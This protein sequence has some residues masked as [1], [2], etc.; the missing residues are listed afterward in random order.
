VAIESWDW[1]VGIVGVLGSLFLMM[2]VLPGHRWRRPGAVAS[3]LW[4]GGFG[5]GCFLMVQAD[6]WWLG[7]VALLLL[8]AGYSAWYRPTPRHDHQSRAAP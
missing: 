5:I 6:A 7:I 2:F 1:W 8:V 3:R 4:G